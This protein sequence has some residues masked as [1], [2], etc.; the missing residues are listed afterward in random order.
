MAAVGFLL[1]FY[2]YIDYHVR[3]RLQQTVA[4]RRS[5]VRRFARGRLKIRNYLRDAKTYSPL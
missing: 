1:I 2:S 5:R 3:N 4:V